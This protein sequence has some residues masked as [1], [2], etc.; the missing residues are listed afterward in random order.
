MIFPFIDTIIL[1]A[2]LSERM[3]DWKLF[4][5]FGKTTILGE[6]IRTALSVSQRIILVAGHRSAEIEKQYKGNSR[7]KIVLNRDYIA[8]GFSS[9]KTALPYINTERFFI[10]L[11]DMPL[12]KPSTYQI[13][14]SY[15]QADAVFPSYKGQTGHPVLIKSYLIPEI[16]SF[17]VGSSMKEFLLQKIALTL[18]GDDPGVVFD[19]DTK[20][21]YAEAKRMLPASEGK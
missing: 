3:G 8:G 4:L 5:P 21:D 18:P 6:T 19:I 9:I 10:V 11:G 7:I 15:D 20:E 17:P 14:S 2:G 12:I 13:L 16:L 1:A